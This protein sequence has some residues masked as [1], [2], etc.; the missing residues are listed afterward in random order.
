MNVTGGVVR[1]Q[2]ATPTSAEQCSIV[3]AG[4][5]CTTIGS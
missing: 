1:A 4:I 3:V 5:C 2:C